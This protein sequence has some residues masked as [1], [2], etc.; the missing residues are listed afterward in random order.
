MIAT[1][2]KM[3]TR[4]TRTTTTNRERLKNTPRAR[5][6]LYRSL[7]RG[8]E[9]LLWWCRRIQ[10]ELAEAWVFSFDV[11]GVVSVVVQVEVGRVVVVGQNKNRSTEKV[12]NICRS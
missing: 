7:K 9:W 5:R 6:R 4:A 3:K 8:R 10:N 11:V 12:N 1:M 2:A